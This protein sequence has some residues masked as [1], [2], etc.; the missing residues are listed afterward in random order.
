MKFYILVIRYRFWLSIAGLAIAI[1]LNV[2]GSAG[3]WPSFPLYFVSV[4][5]LVSHFLIGPLRLAQGPMEEGNL[6]EV[7]KI[8][9]SVWYPKLLI[10]PVR[11]GYYTIKGQ[12]AMSNKDFDTA[13]KYLKE[14][15]SLGSAIPQA[16]GSNKLQL[17]LMAMQ[18]NDL[19]GAEGYV[20]NA[21]RLGLVDKDSEAVAH[22]TLCQ[23]YMTK[24]QTKAAKDFFRKAKEC[25]PKTKQVVDQIKE[26]EKYIGRM[27]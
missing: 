13:E 16:E 23:I 4:I 17:G 26:I 15:S 8:L 22:L 10:K 27:Q 3:F 20:R 11:S 5:G 6:E 2:T 7:E 21:L 1:L 9:A 25:K 19:K 18:K 12:L 14:S 24:R